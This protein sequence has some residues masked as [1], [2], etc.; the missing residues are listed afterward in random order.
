[1]KL[2][3]WRMFAR[4]FDRSRRLLL[5][6]TGLAILQSAALVP[7]ALVVQNV[8]DNLIP[9]RDVTGLVWSGVAVLGLYLVAGLL[10]LC[11]RFLVLKS[12]KASITSLRG[13]LLERIYALPR[14][15]FDRTSQGK[16]HAI[17]VWDS[18]RLDV[19]S[20]ALVGS[21]M[22]AVIV[23]GGLS[24]IL[25]ILNPG[26]FAV[27]L[28]VVP[29][30]LLVG[31]L[32]GTRVRGRVRTW[33]VAF[34]EFSSKNQLALRAMTLAKVQAAERAEMASR[35]AEHAE[36][37]RTGLRMAW[38]Q[39]A[40]TIVQNLVAA[41]S[42]AVVLVLGGRAVA[43]GEMTTGE[44]LSFYAILALLLRE[45]STI[46]SSIPQVLAGYES[47]ARIQAILE[48]DER[49]PY[50][51]TR[52]IDFAGE[53][54][55]EGVSFGYGREEILRDLSFRVGAGEHVA[56][57]GPNGA[58]KS[59]L[60]NLMLGLY[61][62]QTGSVLA[63]GIPYD[64]LDVRHLRRSIGVVLQDPVIFPGT[65]AENIAYG[66]P[67]AE[68]EEI[69]RA[70]TWS[71][72]DAFIDNLP[73]GYETEVGDEGGL[74][75]GGQRQRIAIARALVARP[76]LLILDEPTTHLDDR[77]IDQLI[78][79]LNGFPGAPTVLMISH[80][81]A[82]ARAVDSVQHLRDGRVVNGMEEDGSVAPALAEEAI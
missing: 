69:R 67:D 48:T 22:P 49:E 64:E 68:D 74:L 10:A 30:L 59:T 80:D 37:G 29:L 32:L 24:A 23:A 55:L 4:T 19:M 16:L 58:G 41:S 66:R 26:L 42:G 72:A 57:F 53:L 52:R 3:A 8:F 77:S 31:R 47:M 61:K 39:S 1:V 62:P 38:L 63:D 60:V 27:L 13:S 56:I 46:L 11:T 50:E 81:P 54:V 25:V 15:Y 44:L 36:V 73:D 21:L 33:R 78:A 7:V 20:N 43:R 79:N 2:A 82:V 18:E 17:L 12:T 6:S 45:L 5:A 14:A 9:K 65:I 70:A 40:Y 51:G 35:R 76:A 71:T 75:S 34:E 28:A